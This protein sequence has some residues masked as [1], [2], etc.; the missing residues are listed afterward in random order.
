MHLYIVSSIRTNNF[1]DKLLIDKIGKMWE[2]TNQKLKQHSTSIYGVYYDYESN[3]K[4]DYSLSVA[5]EENIGTSLINLPDND[6]YE[7][8]KVDTTDEQG[9][10][11][12]WSKIW[13]QEESGL[14]ARKYS[15]DFEKY[16]PNGHVE[17]HIAIK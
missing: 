6:K 11:N 5:I 13:E 3:Y 10:F 2:R 4:G 1:N 16:Y 12:T 15:Y 8:F 7:I 17:I 14:L 9:I